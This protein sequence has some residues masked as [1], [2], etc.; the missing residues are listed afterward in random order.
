MTYTWGPQKDPDGTRFR[1]WA[2]AA[3]HIEI[4]LPDKRSF[5]MQA[6][7]DGWWE[8]LLDVSAGARYRF[9][10][11]GVPVPDPASRRQHGDVHG[12]S[13]V[14][15]DSYVW[16]TTG[17]RTRPWQE[18]VLCELHA[19]LCGGFRGIV[20][21]LDALAKTG[22]TAIELMPAGDF[23]GQRNWGYDGVLPYAPDEAYGTPDDLKYLID[24]AHA[25]GLMVLLDVV[26]NH[27]G[28]DGN[29]LPVYAPQ[30]FRSDRETPWG[31]AIDFGRPQVKRFY[32]ENALYW[33]GEFR[34]DGLRFDAVHAIRDS[35][36]LEEMGREV[37]A[38][39]PDR[40]LVLENEDNNAQL[41]DIYRAQW[42]D[43]LHNV[44]HVLLTGEP[45][46][47]YADFVAEPTAKLA[48]ALAEGFVFQG[49]YVARFGKK[50][51]SKSSHLPATSFVFFLQNHDQVG[52]RAF[53]ERLILLANERALKAAVA[54]QL[55]CPQI[56]MLFMGEEGGARE[57]FLFFTDHRDAALAR[58]V[59]K[60]RAAEFAKFPQFA[61]NISTL[62][63]P[64]A[65]ETFEDCQL[66]PADPE[67]CSF[68]TRL[69]ALRREKIVPHLTSAAGDYG[70]PIGDRAVL[71]A[72]RLADGVR[73]TV[74]CNLS[75]MPIKA[76]LPKQD[77]FYGDAKGDVVP[78]FTTVAWIER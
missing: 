70:E 24:E 63:D 18:T 16:R 26:Y 78:S 8:S 62:P 5:G 22:I 41:L 42:N 48:R 35:G 68:Y 21:R 19:G 56:P 4:E 67:W 32:I 75:E 3:K 17:W 76:N 66:G 23:P 1:L 13:A 30:F 61:A 12:W 38:A 29:Y 27:F 65:P 55:L 34:F 47:Y 74:A 9:R 53:G 7:A 28:P 52:N 58:A 15:E 77:P 60:G 6:K 43:D 20:E 44:I 49:E 59:R 33:L 73:L 14:A 71:V 10:V 72:W 40:H 2:P 54:L 51:G 45:G 36:F 25:R 39:C 50:R 11:D 46:G 69:L 37:L 57:P 31:N 64:N